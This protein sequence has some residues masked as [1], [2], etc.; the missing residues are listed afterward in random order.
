MRYLRLSTGPEARDAPNGQRRGERRNGRKIAARL[1]SHRHV[2]PSRQRDSR[3]GWIDAGRWRQ[4]QSAVPRFGLVIGNCFANSILDRCMEIR[5]ETPARVVR[6]SAARERSSQR[7][8]PGAEGRR[9]RLRDHVCSAGYAGQAE[10]LNQ[11]AAPADVPTHTAGV[12]VFLRLA[13]RRR[14]WPSFSMDGRCALG[15]QAPLPAPIWSGCLGWP[16]WSLWGP[17]LS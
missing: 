13:R 3:K 10:T 1:L 6:S 4:G 8:C 16:P 9:G 2:G 14:C 12:L 7:K 17:S 11:S 15:Y 5:R